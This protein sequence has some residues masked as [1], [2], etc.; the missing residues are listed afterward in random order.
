MDFIVGEK[1][2]NVGDFVFSI[3]N[4]DDYNRQVNTFNINKEGGENK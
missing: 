1:F 2:Y 4:D 3:N